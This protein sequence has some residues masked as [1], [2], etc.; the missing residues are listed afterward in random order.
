MNNVLSFIDENGLFVEAHVYLDIL[1]VDDYEK[2]ADE[3][4]V[5]LSERIHDLI[6]KK[7]TENKAL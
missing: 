2:I 3:N 5:A 1:E 6:A 4:T 7:L